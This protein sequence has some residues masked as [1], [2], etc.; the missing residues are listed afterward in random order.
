MGRIAGAASSGYAVPVA[1]RPSSK[2]KAPREVEVKPPKRPEIPPAPRPL[3]LSGI[4]GQDQAVSGLRAAVQSGRIHHAW[5][6]HG[7]TGVGKFTTALAFAALILD[8]TSAPD[9]S[10][11]IEP[12]P[13]SQTQH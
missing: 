2:P 3:P 12:D 11:Q 8:P 7:P 9:L 4:I 10:G 13:Q 5:V 6:F 1:K